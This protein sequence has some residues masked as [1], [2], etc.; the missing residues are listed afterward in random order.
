LIR[1]VRELHVAPSSLLHREALQNCQSMGPP[2]KSGSKY[3]AKAS[4][5]TTDASSRTKKHRAY[6]TKDGRAFPGG[7]DW[8]CGDAVGFPSSLD[9][10][11]P[12]GCEGGFYPCMMW[13][14]PFDVSFEDMPGAGEMGSDWTIP[15]DQHK[16]WRQF[17][18]DGTE[19]SLPMFCWQP[20]MPFGLLPEEP[21]GAGNGVHLPII[22]RGHWPACEDSSHDEL[23]LPPLDVDDESTCTALLDYLTEGIDTH[24]KRRLPL[25]QEDVQLLLTERDDCDS[26]REPT[27]ATGS[28][29]ASDG[30]ALSDASGDDERCAEAGPLQLRRASHEP[31]FEV[32]ESSPAASSSAVANAERRQRSSST[33]NTTAM[34]RNIP[35]KYTRDMLVEQLNKHLKGQFDFVY[36]PIDFK[37]KC[38]VGYGF[39]NFCSAEA[40]DRFV[41]LFDGV[42]VRKCLPGLNSKKIAEVMPARYK[43]LDE[44]VARLRNSQFITDLQLHPEWMPLIFDGDG[45]ELEFPQPEAGKVVAISTI[46]RHGNA[47][48]GE[49]FQKTR[50]EKQRLLPQQSQRKRR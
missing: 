49:H 14:H 37:N 2:K 41:E 17:N 40:H 29:V 47:V 39:I 48:G 34:L 7:D 21:D 1:F 32:S 23:P 3:Q 26:A 24:P 35:N 46:R 18:I 38:N 9:A 11:Y 45:N 42:D 16:A 30:A 4:N 25:R 33:E 27:V 19:Y 10:S 44:N 5:L 22:P 12:V 50:L 31:E 28:T 43:G 20:Y 15:L 6:K 36:L 13:P 8:G